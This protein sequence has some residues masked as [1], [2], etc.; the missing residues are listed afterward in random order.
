M[1]RI[2]SKTKQALHHVYNSM[3][4]SE[5]VLFFEHFL[6]LYS[7][8][9]SI[10]KSTINSCFQLYNKFSELVMVILTKMYSEYD[11]NEKTCFSKVKLQSKHLINKKLYIFIC[12]VI[13][14]YIYK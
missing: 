5:K 1:V 13:I 6:I 3:Y 10:S 12:I 8:Q 9:I 4:K 7:L 2:S 14:P 11:S